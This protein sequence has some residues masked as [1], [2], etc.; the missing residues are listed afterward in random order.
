MY[1][2]ACRPAR[3]DHLDNGSARGGGEIGKFIRQ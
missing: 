3:A 1:H 2:T